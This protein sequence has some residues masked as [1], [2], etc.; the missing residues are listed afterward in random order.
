MSLNFAVFEGRIVK[1]MEIKLS[2]NGK[3]LALY[4]VAV[5]R[6]FK[7]EEGKYD[8]DF[9]HCLTNIASEKQKEYLT[10][11]LK[12]GC[13]VIVQGRMRQSQRQLDNEIKVES[14]TLITQE[15]TPISYY[16]QSSN[17]EKTEEKTTETAVDD[18]SIQIPV[19]EDDEYPFIY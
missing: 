5:Q 19:I 13:R 3:E 16:K 8:A 2:K 14:L 10:N 17:E 15:I 1:D 7:N 12:K 11:N 6:H 4:T 18:V 9:I